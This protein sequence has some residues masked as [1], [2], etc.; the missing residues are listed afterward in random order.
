MRAC[1]IQA[2]SSPTYLP[3]L[4]PLTNQAGRLRRNLGSPIREST[5]A[6]L[7]EI[8]RFT[9]VKHSCPPASMTING[10]VLLRLRPPSRLHHED[11][12]AKLIAGACRQRPR[13]VLTRS[14][15]APL[16]VTTS[17]RGWAV[18]DFRGEAHDEVLKWLDGFAG[19]G[20]WGRRKSKYRSETDW[21]ADVALWRALLFRDVF[22]RIPFV[23]GLASLSILLHDSRSRY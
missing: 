2:V 18:L 16:C 1:P 23:A 20:S 9:G 21:T 11:P 6:R 22:L 4:S 10:R 15:S 14:Q 12:R 3:A 17:R 5:H 7:R 13:H 19:R 8:S